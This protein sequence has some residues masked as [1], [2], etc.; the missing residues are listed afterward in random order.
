MASGLGQA[1]FQKPEFMTLDYS[2]SLVL[3]VGNIPETSVEQ[4]LSV[5]NG[6]GHKAGPYI[7][8]H[9]TDAPQCFVH[10]AG[11]GKLFVAHV[12]NMLQAAQ[13]VEKSF[14]A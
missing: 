14:I 1:L 6:T 2:G 11:P 10:G 13:A 5:R 9:V 8:N 7:H 4:V 3:T 12:L